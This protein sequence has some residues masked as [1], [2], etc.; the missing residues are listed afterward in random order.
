MQSYSGKAYIFDNTTGLLVYTLDNPNP[1]GTSDY[2]YFGC[3]V[4][5]SG[6]YIIVGAPY[7]GDAGGSYSGKA[8]VYKLSKT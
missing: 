7:E 2:D 1:F 5:I 6:N 8:Y 3:S 4:S